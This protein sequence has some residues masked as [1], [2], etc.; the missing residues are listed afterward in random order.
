MGA[1]LTFQDIQNDELAPSKFVSSPN[2]NVST[3][4]GAPAYS[5]QGGSIYVDSTAGTFYVNNSGAS[6]TTWVSLGTVTGNIEN[7]HYRKETMTG[8]VASSTSS[9]PITGDLVGIW[10]AGTWAASGA[11]NTTVANAQGGGSSTSAWIAGGNTVVTTGLTSATQLWN[12]TTWTNPAAP[13]AATIQQGVG[14]GSQNAGLIAGGTTGSV[15]SSSSLWNGTVWTATGVLGTAKSGLAG[16]G[17][18]GASF[19]TGGTTGTSV[20]NTELF[21]GAT[22]SASSGN[23]SVIKVFLNGTGSQNSG[24]IV[25][26]STQTSVTELFNGSTWIISGTMSQS[27]QQTGTGGSVYSAIAA[28]GTIGSGITT[29]ELFNGSTWL[30]STGMAATRSGASGLGSQ[31]AGISAGGANSVSVVLSATELHSQATYRKM[32]SRHVKTAKNIGIYTGSSTVLLK[33]YDTTVTYPPNVYLIL[34][35]TSV[36]AVANETDLSGGFTIASIQSGTGNT[37][38]YN[39]STATSMLQVCPGMMIIVTSATSSVNNGTFIVTFVNNATPYFSVTNASG[40]VQAGSAGT[41]NIISSLLAVTTPSE[42]DIIIGKTDA[43]GFVTLTR[44]PITS[45]VLARLR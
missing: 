29:T 39:L 42:Q 27:K 31:S 24:L 12:G 13:L 43:S 8:T 32:F 9:A 33:G 6:G 40:V 7:G 22:W 30:L 35:K 4:S 21:N 37:W 1:K 16:A 3:G 5:T 17:T 10:G 41:V 45:S 23:L 18:S 15:V 36:S 11:L 20:S 38:N 44:E 19:V 25:G 14:S 34:N 26:G 28:G 2:L